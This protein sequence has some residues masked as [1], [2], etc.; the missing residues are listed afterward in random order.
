MRNHALAAALF[1]AGLGAVGLVGCAEK[2]P[3]HVVD[4]NQQITQ[5]NATLNARRYS[6]ETYPG[7]DTRVLMQSDSTVNAMCRFGD[8]WASGVIINNADGRT[9]DK[10]KCQTAG[11]GKGLHGCLPESVFKGKDYAQQDGRCDNNLTAL[12]KFK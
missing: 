6:A 12:E 2:V 7:I 4:E 1:I 9:I 3:T 5:A 11:R 8:G 10:I